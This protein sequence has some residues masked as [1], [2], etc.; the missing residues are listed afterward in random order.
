MKRI[1]SYDGHV[2]V[3]KRSSGSAKRSK[4]KTSSMNKHKRRQR[5]LQH[6]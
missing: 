2:T 1:K 6:S 4:I 3:S 5:G